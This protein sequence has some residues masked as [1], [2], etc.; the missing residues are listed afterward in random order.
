M[1]S[2]PADT[3]ACWANCLA[4]MYLI[5]A[6]STGL[7]RWG[8]ELTC[9]GSHLRMVDLCSK[10]GGTGVDEEPGMRSLICAASVLAVVA[11]ACLSAGSAGASDDDEETPTIKTVMEKA[12]Q[13]TPKSPVNNLKAAAQG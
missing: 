13:E 4:T 8:N 7:A 2:G 10:V 3:G 12:A 9:A 6:S 11:F 5:P 1:S